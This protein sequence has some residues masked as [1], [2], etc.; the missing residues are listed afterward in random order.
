MRI[1]KPES[2][3]VMAVLRRLKHD[4]TFCFLSRRFKMPTYLYVKRL[5]IDNAISFF[6]LQ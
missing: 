4:V 6:L 2:L 3:A 1:I 5:G